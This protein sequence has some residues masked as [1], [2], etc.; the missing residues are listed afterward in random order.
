MGEKAL[1]ADKIPPRAGGEVSS[2]Q[3]KPVGRRGVGARATN[4]NVPWL[5][6]TLP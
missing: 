3:E 1:M 6:R 5:L 4:S 2:C